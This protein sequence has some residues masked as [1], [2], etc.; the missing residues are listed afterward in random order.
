MFLSLINSI[1]IYYVD[2]SQV[3]CISALCHYSR[4]NHISGLRVI[5]GI[6]ISNFSLVSNV[7]ALKQ[8]ASLIECIKSA[9]FSWYVVQQQKI[10][11]EIPISL[12]W[13]YVFSEM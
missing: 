10:P 9:C 5:W 8:C 12:R 7:Y 13:K 4:I 2:E 1:D 6:F 3:Y 11:L